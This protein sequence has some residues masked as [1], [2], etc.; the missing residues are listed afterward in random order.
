LKGPSL[1]LLFLQEIISGVARSPQ[2]SWG[3]GG[4]ANERTAR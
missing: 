4:G 2:E 3:S 1:F